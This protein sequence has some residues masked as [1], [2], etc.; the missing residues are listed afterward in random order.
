M[1]LEAVLGAEVREAR[2]LLRADAVADLCLPA[3]RR[4]EKG[5]SGPR[6]L[7]GILTKHR[8]NAKLNARSGSRSPIHSRLPISLANTAILLPSAIHSADWCIR[9]ILIG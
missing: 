9:T 4:R 5:I 6:C 8:V 2:Q 3:G 1:Y 7:L